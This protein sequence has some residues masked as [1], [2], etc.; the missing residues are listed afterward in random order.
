MEIEDS[1]NRKMDWSLYPARTK[2]GSIL[3]LSSDP[4]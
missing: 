1:P 2:A 4:L 3:M